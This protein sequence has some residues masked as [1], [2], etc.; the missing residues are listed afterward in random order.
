MK[1]LFAIKTLENSIGGAERVTCELANGLSTRGHDISVLTFDRADSKGFYHLNTSIKRLYVSANDTAKK[2]RLAEIP[3]LLFKL[4]KTILNESPDVVVASMHSMFVPLRLA[5]IGTGLRVIFSEHTVPAHYKGKRLE[6]AALVAMG[7][8]ADKITVASPSHPPL[9]PAIL[10]HKMTA[11]TN[12]V[13][14][15]FIQADVSSAGH[16]K[17]ILSVGRLDALKDQAVLIDA[18]AAI[19]KKF[20][21]WTLKIIGEGAE[22]QKLEERIAKYNL[23]NRI[24]LPGALSDINPAYEQAQIF[25]MPSRYES[26]GLVTAEAITHG[27]PVVGFADCTGTNELIIDGKNGFLLQERSPQS[28]GNALSQLMQSE[29]MRLKFAQGSKDEARKFNYDHIITQ[30]EK[31]IAG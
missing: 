30:W 3:N 10:R 5:L 31:V 24:S 18:F 1:I 20:P 14:S 27:L 2:T 19:S 9:Y 6:F 28:L 21:D 8:L 11:V 15:S 22:R 13:S 25:V 7:L 4:R 29:D 16:S 23:N 26:F 12:P 17:T